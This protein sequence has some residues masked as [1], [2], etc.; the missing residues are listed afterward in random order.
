[1]N[2]LGF[3]LTALATW[4]VL[5]LPRKWASFPLLGSVLLI[6][7]TQV[8]EFG[9]ASLT[10]IRILIFAGLCRVLLKQEQT[11]P[12]L[13]R[14]EVVLIVWAL[15]MLIS[16]CLRTGALSMVR[17]GDVYTILGVYFLFRVFLRAPQDIL[18]AFKSLCIILLPV[19]AFML[20]EKIKGT[21]Y[22]A[23]LFGE[24]DFTVLRHGHYR[25]RGLYAN[26]I[27]AGTNA[28]V[29]LPIAMFLWK[30][31]RKVA[32][33]GSGAI[34][35]IIFASGSSGPIMTALAGS[36]AVIFWTYRRYLRTLKWGFILSLFVLNLIM[37]DPVYFLIARLDINAGSTGWYRAKLIEG[38]IKHI[39]DWW[40]VGT[41]YTLDWVPV[42]TA[43]IVGK[44]ADMTNHFIQMGVWGGLLLMGLFVRKVWL[45]FSSLTRCL[46]HLQAS[47]PDAK[48]A[49]IL[50]SILFAHVITFFSVSYFEPSTLV[51]FYW[52]LAAIF[53][54][55]CFPGLKKTSSLPKGE[56]ILQSDPLFANSF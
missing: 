6:P 31:D 23:L 10:P 20:L 46:R 18:F 11:P 29:C 52:N 47:S 17:V 55:G 42:G 25:A 16:E 13:N 8:I 3:F 36:G 21:N 54:L 5:R 15:W 22:A 27:L 43:W 30:S 41:D 56:T 28:A 50:G 51:L 33:C 45:G 34:A 35:A 12:K 2:G 19:A 7:R 44:H 39:S 1:M 26:A 37:N 4:L 32:I 53:S 40:L 24:S 49:W 9:G 14:F 48:L 38:A